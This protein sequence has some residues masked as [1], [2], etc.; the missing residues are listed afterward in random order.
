MCNT[1]TTPALEMKLRVGILQL[2][3]RIGSITSN[4]ERANK[5][6]NTKLLGR[7]LDILVLPEFGL[8]GYKFANRAELDPYLE[9]PR[10][11]GAGIE[12]A[13]NKSKELKC[14]V[15]LGY[16]EKGQNNKIYNSASLVDPNGEIDFNF[17]KSFLYQT[18]EAFDCSENE[19]G[20]ESASI[21]NGKIKIMVG[22]CMDL[23]P[24]KFEAPFEAYEFAN[25]ALECGANLVVCP[26]AWLN[27]ESPS[28]I[29]DVEEKATKK[30]KLKEEL[31]ESLSPELSTVN[32]WVLRMFPFLND[33]RKKQQNN[34]D[35]RVGFLCANR[36]GWEEDILYAGSSSIFTFKG[37][38]GTGNLGDNVEYYGS[39][40]GLEENLLYQEI[41][42]DER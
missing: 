41:E 15:L 13:K 12:W 9:S 40:G 27:S 28:L 4:I 42:I 14:H 34:N 30:Q 17:R 2:N 24:Y 32:Y 23:N 1:V 7:Q 8:H 22:I 6:L 38:P 35:R 16:P 39:L 10:E 36:S 19:N 20:F 21:M 18:D 31:D 5:I 33:P 3:P 26:M 25:K 37:N 29:E 11:G